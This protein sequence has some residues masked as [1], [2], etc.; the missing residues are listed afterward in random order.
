MLDEALVERF[1]KLSPAERRLLMRAAEAGEADAAAAGFPV[2]P[3]SMPKALPMVEKEERQRPAPLLTRDEGAGVV[4]AAGEAAVL[5]GA[6]GGGK[7]Q[8]AL[9]L[10]IAAAGGVDRIAPFGGRR[11]IEMAHGPAVYLAYEDD[12]AWM[13]WRARRIA[14]WL[15]RNSGITGDP[16]MTAAKNPDRLR[17][18]CPDYAAALFEVSLGARPGSPQALPH[19]SD[20]WPYLWQDLRKMEPRLIVVDPVALAFAVDGYGAVGV[21]RFIGA[22]RRELATLEKPC[23]ALLVAHT[24]RA[25]RRKQRDEADTGPMGSVAWT[26]RP[27]SV[28][29]LEP[30]EG[31]KDDDDSKTHRQRLFDLRLMKANYARRGTLATLEQMRDRKNRPIAFKLAE[32]PEGATDEDETPATTDRFGQRFD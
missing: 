16:Y 6:G 27:R 14:R 4:L 31:G 21:G 13:E 28:L 5:A 17:L 19:E 23:G 3:E 9:Q 10:A 8:L 12:A 32:T 15:D 1:A 29:H 25:G 22:I 30:T 2:K 18:Y 20:W 7:S 26:D 11:E 24:S